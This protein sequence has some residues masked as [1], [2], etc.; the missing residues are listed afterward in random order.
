MNKIEKV[1]KVAI[2]NCVYLWGNY[3]QYAKES[4]CANND[5]SSQP[6]CSALESTTKRSFRKYLPTL[7]NVHVR[8]LTNFMPVNA[9]KQL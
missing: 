3:A 1:N 2:K 4:L 7:A 6:I 8:Q 9:Y 5:N